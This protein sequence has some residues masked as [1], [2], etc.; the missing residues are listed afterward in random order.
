MGQRPQQR[1]PVGAVVFSPAVGGFRGLGKQRPA[2]FLDHPGQTVRLAVS[3]PGRVANNPVAVNSL[4]T[5]WLAMRGPLSFGRHAA[6]ASTRSRSGDP[7]TPALAGQRDDV[8]P[9]KMSISRGGGCSPGGQPVACRRASGRFPGPVKNFRG[10][11]KKDEVFVDRLQRV[12]IVHFGCSHAAGAR[13]FHTFIFLGK[14]AKR[15]VP[16][17]P[18]SCLVVV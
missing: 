3:W 10:R 5:R 17:L 14:G 4:P 18:A 2:K 1:P 16:A 12:V 9:A 13:P 7:P 6:G 11:L 15:C 8:Q